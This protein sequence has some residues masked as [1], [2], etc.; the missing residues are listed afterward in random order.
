LTKLEVEDFPA[1][2]GLLGRIVRMD[3]IL[4]ERKST[5][6][7]SPARLNS[8]VR[9]PDAGPSFSTPTAFRSDPYTP[10]ISSRSRWQDY[11][12]GDFPRGGEPD[13]ES[14][15]SR[16]RKH[17]K[18]REDRSRRDTHNKSQSPHKRKRDEVDY[19]GESS[20]GKA[21]R[22]R[23]GKDSGDPTSASSPLN[24]S[25]YQERMETEGAAAGD[26]RASNGKA[27]KHQKSDRK[28]VIAS[29]S[30]SK[31][32]PDGKKNRWRKQ[33]RQPN[34]QALEE[35]E[36][37]LKDDFAALGTEN[38]QQRDDV[39]FGAGNGHNNHKRWF[40]EGRSPKSVQTRI[41]RRPRSPEV[42]VGTGRSV[43]RVVITKAAH[44]KIKYL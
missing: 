22:S 24:V 38:E 3:K 28:G 7:E 21:R 25:R 15:S 18:D 9:L 11:E 12:E 4:K 35:G 30:A 41:D 1:H 8:K 13:P 33:N 14:T 16:K 36:I 2:M 29:E 10:R 5:I 32:T 43:R 26:I 40:N 31:R 6:P 34:E 42:D 19:K 27:S 37:V 17:G 44:K 23:L 20:S 39:T